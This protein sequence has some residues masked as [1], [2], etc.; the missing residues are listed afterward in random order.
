MKHTDKRGTTIAQTHK[1]CQ[2]RSTYDAMVISQPSID[3][4]RLNWSNLIIT[5]NDTDMCY[6]IIRHEL[7]AIVL[8]RFGCPRSV[9]VYHSLTIA[10]MTNKILTTHGKSIASLV[11]KSSLNLGGSGQGSADS[12]VLWHCHMESLLDALDKFSFSFQFTD[13]SNMIHYLQYIIGYIC[14]NSIRCN[15]PNNKPSDELICITTT[16][17]QS[18]QQL[19]RHIRGDLSLPKCLFTLITWM[20]TTNRSNSYDNHRRIARWQEKQYVAWKESKQGGIYT[21]GVVINRVPTLSK[22]PTYVY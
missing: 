1:G 4:T 10:Q 13:I 17:L 8:C 21:E 18:W 22:A 5:F 16:V 19:L 20:P 11:K 15:L 6:R 3:T 12:G 2:G 7:Y 14:N 9:A